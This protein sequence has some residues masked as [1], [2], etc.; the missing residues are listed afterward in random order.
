M[1]V[2]EIIVNGTAHEVSKGELAFEQVVGFAYETPPYGEF[3]E[4]SVTYRRGP[5][6]NREGI[7]DPGESVKVKNHMI[8]DV[9]ALIDRDTGLRR[10]LDE[11]Y[12]VSIRAGHLLVEGVPYLGTSREILR[13][14]IV[15]P[16]G[17]FA[18]DELLP[19]ARPHRLLCG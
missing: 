3:T 10:L 13:G 15:M 4:Y 17:D 8:F 1:Q 7:L 2:I 16:L 18:G 5:N 6:G 19:P 12:E 11:G 14:I 9:T